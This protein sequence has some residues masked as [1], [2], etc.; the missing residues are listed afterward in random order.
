MLTVSPL[1]HQGRIFS[2]SPLGGI[3]G[4]WERRLVTTRTSRPGDFDG[5]STGADDGR[6]ICGLG[7]PLLKL[8]SQSFA[9]RIFSGAVWCA[10][11]KYQI[12]FSKLEKIWRREPFESQFRQISTVFVILCGV[13]SPLWSRHRMI[14]KYLSFGSFWCIKNRAMSISLR[15]ATIWI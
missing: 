10:Y 4:D 2:V 6:R 15:T 3:G 7:W 5:T 12:G 11:F 8:L 13:Q 14:W 1:S 9:P